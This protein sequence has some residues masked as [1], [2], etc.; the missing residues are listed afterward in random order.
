MYKSVQREGP[1]KEYK[2][3]GNGP[4]EM[5]ENLGGQRGLFAV[6]FVLGNS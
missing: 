1:S 3:V 4:L 5:G 6:R 2:M